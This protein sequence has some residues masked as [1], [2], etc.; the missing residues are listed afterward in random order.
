MD[1]YYTKA[2]EDRPIIQI[3]NK[4]QAGWPP[5]TECE[6]L[7]KEGAPILQIIWPCISEVSD[8]FL[9]NK[10]SAQFSNY[11]ESSSTI[12]ASGTAMGSLVSGSRELR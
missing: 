3:V 9:K 4:H 6:S 12:S 1:Y 2:S 11:I 5:L 10:K 8:Q 7:L